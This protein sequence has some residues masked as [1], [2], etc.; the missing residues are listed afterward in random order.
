MPRLSTGPTL[1]VKLN[2]RP[3]LSYTIDCATQ[4]LILI[5]IEVVVISYRD[6]ADL[7][8][9]DFLSEQMRGDVPSPSF[10]FGR[11]C[12]AMQINSHA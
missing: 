5:K 3:N 7:R 8:R 11:Q 10:A 1:Y 12:M 6:D 4:R 2:A 9:F